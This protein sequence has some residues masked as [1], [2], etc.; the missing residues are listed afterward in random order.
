MGQRDRP[1]SRKGDGGGLEQS[2]VSYFILLN[3]K[4]VGSLQ[5]NDL[6]ED[7]VRPRLSYLTSL[8]CRF[9]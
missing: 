3:N 1:T 9:F 5:T 8:S 6:D 2:L 7:T 4:C